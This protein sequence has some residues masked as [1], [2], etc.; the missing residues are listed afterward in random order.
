MTILSILA[1]ILLLGILVMIHEAGHF[2]AS[3]ATGIPVKEFSIGFGPKLFSWKSRKYDT[4]FFVRLIPAG[5]YC[6]YYGEDDPEADR[7]DPRALNN[8]KVWKRFFSV[9]MGPMMNF[10]LAFVA[11]VLL[12]CVIG[13]DTQGTVG[14]VSLNS[15]AENSPAAAA[16]LQAGD[17]ILK[18][19][20]QDAAGLDEDGQLR[21]QSLIAAY[22]AGDAPL[23]FTV[24]RGETQAECSAVPRYDEAEQRYLVGITMTYEYIPGYTPVTLPRAM[25]LGADYCVRA[26]GAVLEGLRALVTTREGI[27]NSAGPVG[28]VSMI[29]EETRNYGFSAYVQMMILISVNLGLFNLLPIPG[30]DGSR[31]I[32]LLVEA[33][34]RKPV[35]QKVEAYV[36][37]AGYALL[38][39][40]LLFIT[41]RDVLRIFQR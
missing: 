35:N 27:E 33:V 17:V 21:V 29:A 41:Y 34:R 37:L 38:L 32:F 36:H 18:I 23:V 25:Q 19:N 39:M 4:R 26:G 40:L 31:L 3:R 2:F 28:I 11:A 6:M 24:Q 15:V 8:Q 10:V 13:E 9:A 5:G 14:K 20:G 30:L 16:G 12:F 1:A 7:S 22:R